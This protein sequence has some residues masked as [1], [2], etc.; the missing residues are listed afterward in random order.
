[1]QVKVAPGDRLYMFSD[2]YADQFG[3]I[4]GKER[5]IMSGQLK[6]KLVSIQDKD[7]KAQCE[8]LIRFFDNWK[9]NMKQMDDVTALAIEV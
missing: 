4:E 9:G 8:W 5:K 3:L 7:M 6:K 1:M 2:S